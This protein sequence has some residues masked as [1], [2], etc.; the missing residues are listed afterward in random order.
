MTLHT[1]Y[2]MSYNTVKS[3]IDCSRVVDRNNIVIVAIEGIRSAVDWFK[4]A[5]L[6][7]VCGSLEML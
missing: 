6:L 4:P 1:E 3:H 2:D 5:V 7:I